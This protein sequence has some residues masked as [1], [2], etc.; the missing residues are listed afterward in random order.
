[1]NYQFVTC[2]SLQSSEI[3]WNRRN[4]SEKTASL[5]FVQNLLVLKHQVFGEQ[6]L[7]LS[8]Q[9]DFKSTGLIVRYQTAHFLWKICLKLC[10][11][12][13]LL[14]ACLPQFIALKFQYLFHLG[15]I[16]FVFGGRGANY[17]NLELQQQNSARK[18]K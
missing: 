8:V 6:K 10:W 15:F 3:H 7:P 4:Y 2:P 13:R 18:Y 17:M 14:T 5:H 16:F 9:Q 11:P 12:G 1:M